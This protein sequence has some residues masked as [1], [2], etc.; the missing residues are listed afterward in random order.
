MTNQND[1]ILGS[2]QVSNRFKYEIDIEEAI[3]DDVFGDQ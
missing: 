1:W 3:N 2:H